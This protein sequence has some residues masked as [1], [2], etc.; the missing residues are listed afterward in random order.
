[1]G[2]K[3]LYLN[4][5]VELGGGERSLL[6]LISGLDRGRF[7]P[8]VSCIAEGPLP[9][10]LRRAGVQVHINPWPR[11]ALRIGRGRLTSRL[12]APLAAPAL[13]PHVVRMA[14]LVRREAID[15]IH[16][17]GLKSHL[18][19]SAVSRLTGRPLVWHVRDVLRPGPIRLLY[20]AL[21]RMT[22]SRLVANS[23]AVAGTFRGMP[24]SR[25]SVVYNGLDMNRYCPGAPDPSV[26]A[27]LGIQAGDFVIGAIGALAPLKGHIHLIRAAPAI[28]ERCQQARFVIVGR[29]MYVTTGHAGYR[30]E[31]EAE[32]ARLGVAPRIVFAGY[33]GDPVAVLRC[34]DLLVHSSVY[35]E[36]FGRVIVESMA[37]GIPVVATALGGPTEII[38]SE[39]E[40]LLIPAEDPAAIAGAVTRLIQDSR[41]RDRMAHRGR[42][43]A[44]E[45]FSVSRY[46]LEIQEIY[47]LLE[48][49]RR[50]P[51][52]PA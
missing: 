11:F 20:G 50:E 40:G 6:E 26:R 45:A 44:E 49:A 4:P 41:H 5:S 10:A 22:V 2:L 35:P 23:R 29:E 42:A 15:L 51:E 28:L 47:D 34:F 33:H 13:L 31:L 18:I 32:A 17:N 19:G 3:I 27:S 39:E 30:Q 52:R 36:S 21:A 9:D 16:T 12:L 14:A 38:R 37:C 8:I 7:T 25:L 24:A 46:V 1:M 43:R 48:R